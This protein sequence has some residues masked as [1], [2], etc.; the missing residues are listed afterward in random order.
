MDH[1]SLLLPLSR[2]EDVGRENHTYYLLWRELNQ[3]RDTYNPHYLA[4]ELKTIS[5]PFPAEGPAKVP[6]RLFERHDLT[7]TTGSK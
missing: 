7:Q 1:Y 4:M 6:V 3:C 5:F 2:N